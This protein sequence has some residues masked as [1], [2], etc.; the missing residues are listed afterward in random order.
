LFRQNNTKNLD[1]GSNEKLDVVNSGSSMQ[2]RQYIALQNMLGILDDQDPTLRLSCRS[3]LT[4]SKD[5]FLR[6]LDPLLKEFMDNNRVYKSFTGQVFFLE[7]N[8]VP[9]NVIENFR[10]L[11]NII[12]NTQSEFIKYIVEKDISE[13]IRDQF[14]KQFDYINV[15]Y[16]RK[17]VSDKELK[18]C[19]DKY[20]YAIICITLQFIIGQAVESLNS[21]LFAATQTVNASACEFMELVMKS[22]H[23]KVSLS[24]EITHLIIGFLVKALRQAIDSK[25]NAQQVHLINLIQAIVIDG[26]FYASPTQEKKEEQWCSA[27]NK[28]ANSLFIE[29]D[30]CECIVDGIKSNQPIVRYHYI[31]LSDRIVQFMQMH[32]ENK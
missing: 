4:E 14:D 11:R 12:L 18:Y 23:N 5:N 20:I 19:K 7:E 24:T 15:P 21:Q 29:D 6:I 9:Q 3:W 2:D 16:L 28:C 22:I 13:H 26:N 8:Y 32:I 31:T 25:N 17:M 27:I 10:K 30:L 1:N